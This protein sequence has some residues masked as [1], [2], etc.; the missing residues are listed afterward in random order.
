[1]PKEKLPLLGKHVLFT[2]P[3]N[4]AGAL[5]RLLIERGAR[6]VWMPTI[7]IWP[8]SDYREL[9][10]AIDH[11]SDYEWVGFTSENGIE[12]FLNRL[13]AKGSVSK[14]SRIR[15]LLLS[16]QMLKPWRN[17]ESRLT[18][19]PMN[20]APRVLSMNSGVGGSRGDEFSFPSLRLWVFENPM[21]FL[22]L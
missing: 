2:T 4:Y 18:F 7:E 9:D 17:M 14:P 12:A 11:L 16:S 21:L 10:Q 3:R 5:G 22:S 20:R 1:V 13:S 8:M 19:C 6:I 15:N